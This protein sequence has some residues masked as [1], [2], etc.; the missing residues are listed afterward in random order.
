MPTAPLYFSNF[1]GGLNTRD[2]PNLLQDNEARDLQ[3]VQGTPAG[4]IV[5][6]AGLTTFATLPA[7]P[8]SLYATDVIV[9]T[10][11]VIASDT[12]NLYEIATGTPAVIKSGLTAG[13]WE[14]VSSMIAGGQG[15]IYGMNG[16]DTPQQ[17]SGTGS[18]A[19]WTATT[20]TV[21]NGKY[22][23]LAGNRIW[24][25]G[26]R[27][28][29]SRVYFSDLIPANNGPITWPTQNVAIFDENDGQPI[30]GLGHVGPYI[31]VCKA[32]KLYI[33][34]DMNTGDAR[35]LSDNIGCASHRSIA[36]GP[37][38]T[39][40]LAPERGA[41]LTDG[42]KIT[43]I[44]D[45]IKPDFDAI[46]TSSLATAA[47][48]YWNGHY[49]L[50]VSRASGSND[51]VYDYDSVLQSW[52]RHTFGSNQFAVWTP[53]SE[54]VLC[55]ASAGTPIVNQC[56]VPGIMVDS[57]TPFTWRWRGPW[58]SPMFYRRRLFPTP[59]FRKRLR[60]LRV[61][62]VG[63]V[64]CSCAVDR[65]PSSETLK[66][67]NIFGG[68]TVPTLARMYSFGVHYA[69]G[70]GFSGT[71]TTSDMVLAY[72]LGITDRRDGLAS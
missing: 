2:A 60:Q 39:Y 56:F 6:R 27:A 29:P 71:S 72:E 20:G 7:A 5:K 65:D 51:T 43:P 47:G 14:W 24:V 23:L 33:I 58:Q 46:S 55:S 11:T 41:Y 1:S 67:A 8:L 52:W 21:P 57:G 42:S 59:Y 35:R 28:N 50:S 44:S 36:E 38:G 45:V 31:L 17:W 18:T 66:Q 64:D 16:V 68:A 9:T 69:F 15:P 49:Y 30:T 32:R 53:F 34:F 22:M 10:G 40:F 61:E 19:N 62:G 54:A 3:N 63:T 48:V 13:R 12:T 70:M 4:A 25:T 26:V 37:E